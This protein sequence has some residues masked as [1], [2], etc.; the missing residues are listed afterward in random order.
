MAGWVTPS[1]TRQQSGQPPD[2]PGTLESLPQVLLCITPSPAIDRTAH[3]ERIS[4]GDVLRPTELLVLPG[5]KGVNAARAAARLG[6]NVMTTGIAGGHAGR[7]I[8]EALAEEG[9]SPAWATAAA[10]SRTAYVTID[11]SGR[12]VLVYE[13]PAVA[14]D[15]EFAAFLELLAEELLPR[16]RRA[17]V[18]GTLPAG[19]DVGLYGRIV[20]T[21]RLAGV[22][23]L[24]DASGEGLVA[25]L[26]EDPEGVKIGRIEAVQA[27]LVDDVASAADAAVALVAAGATLAVVT[28]GARDVAAADRDTIWQLGVPHVD[29]VNAVGSGDAFNAAVSLALI[30]GAP[31]E[32]ALVKGVA[33][34]SANAMVLGA[35]MLD[36]DVS[37]Q[38]EPTVTVTAT[39]R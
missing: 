14:T 17:V 30:D 6:G 33:A 37:R 7:W 20:A 38:L 25:A 21:C 31:T 18:A 1:M 12:S 19:V 27:G 23:L 28:D 32:T 22:P 11:D 3:V 5:G 29:A 34:G 35:G 8:V 26:A 39:R 4:S 9:L 10:E 2:E 36:A 15:P 16:C 24:V 13:R